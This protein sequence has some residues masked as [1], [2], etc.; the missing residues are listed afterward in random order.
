MRMWRSPPA[1]LPS[2]F[3]L[4]GIGYGPASDS[5]GHSNDTPER[6]VVVLT[7]LTGMP[8]PAFVPKSAWRVFVAPMNA[9]SAV[10]SVRIGRPSTR[11][12][13]TFVEGNGTAQLGRWT[14]LLTLGL[15]ATDPARPA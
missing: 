1:P 10:E 7:V 8:Y 13:Q 2:I 5:S 3:W 4:A 9:I 12:F 6:G 14:N 15:A 11:L